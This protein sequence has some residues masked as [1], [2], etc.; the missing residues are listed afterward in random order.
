VLVGAGARDGS[1]KG[2]PAVAWA[3]ALGA[4]RS[5]RAPLALV[6]ACGPG[7]ERALDELEHALGAAP[8][9][10]AL[11]GAGRVVA[12][13]APVAG[14]GELL[15]HLA[16]RRC[17]SAATRGRATSR[18]PRGRRRDRRGPDRSAPLRG[19]RARAARARHRAVRSVPSRALSARRRRAHH[20]CMHRIDPARIADAA[21]EL[22]A[23]G[24][25]VR[26]IE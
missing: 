10:A 21:R 26:A 15:A 20:A 13:R 8:A 4:L 3:A 25:T 2:V 24:R 11:A 22:L 1:S 12:L 17:T 6:L 16:R 7:E 5:A 14:L 23:G 9:G 19:E 18:A